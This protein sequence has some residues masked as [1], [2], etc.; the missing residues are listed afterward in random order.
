V[1]LRE[2]RELAAEIALSLA[3]D[4]EMRMFE[5]PGDMAAMRRAQ[6]AWARVK[7]I[8]RWGLRRWG[9]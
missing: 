7:R 2:L 1:T 9:Q 4:A 3:E 6:E 8:D 5:Q